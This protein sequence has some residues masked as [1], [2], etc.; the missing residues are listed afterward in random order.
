MDSGPIGMDSGRAD[1]GRDSGPRDSGPVTTGD[2]ISGALGNRAVRFSWEGSGP[3]ST[4]YVNYEVNQ[5]P[6][7]VRWRVSAASMSIGYRPVYDDTFLGPGGLD[8]EGDVFMDIELSTSGLS[9]I[10][11][12]TISIFGRSF[13]TTASGSFS[14]QTFD[15]VGETPSGSIAN[16]TPY[17]WYSGDATTAFSPGDTGV[18]LRL[19]P[20][21]PSDALIVNRVEICF[22]AD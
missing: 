15:D 4:A 2:C 13:N 14:W 12:V 8:L 7:T 16:S 21:P 10:R 11:N 18:Y 22:D 9:S 17:E 5:L 20:G 3:G 19:R 1:A 6:D